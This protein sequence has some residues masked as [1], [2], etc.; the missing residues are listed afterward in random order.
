MNFD[1]DTRRQSFNLIAIVAAFVTNIL[2]NLKPLDGLTIA[3]IS[4]QYFATVP[5]VP[6]GYA[7]AIW[8]LIYLGLISLGI[9][10]ALPSQKQRPHARK[11]GYALT[12]SSLAQI[13]W[14]IAFQYQQFLLSLGLIILV[15]LPLV[16]LYQ[17]LASGPK[18]LPKKV[19]WLM[20]IPVSIYCA[21]L[22]VAT[23]VNAA[24]VLDFLGWLGWGLGATFWTVGLL[25]VGILLA[26]VVTLKHRDPA[27][28]GVFV[29]AWV[30][31][32]IKNW[33]QGIIPS[34]AIA[35]A[36]GLLGLCITIIWF[37]ERLSIY[38]SLPRR[39]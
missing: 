2:A 1:R 23:I 20:Q 17:R 24:C 36:L 14:V 16:W 27:Y 3:A 15:L 6:A 26:I 7:F 13:F 8:G 25:V 31:I 30:A 9:Y 4:D 32:A 5:I 10:Q 35:A 34:V 21:W 11:L 28:G 33:S 38:P 19:K 37:P 29:W 39:R 12:W 22:T 18:P